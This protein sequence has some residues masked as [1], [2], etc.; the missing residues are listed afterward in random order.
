MLDSP[1]A[2]QSEIRTERSSAVESVNLLGFLK[3]RMLASKVGSV[4]RTLC[5]KDTFSNHHES[6]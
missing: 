6:H 2:H 5:I 1:L 4:L 3:V